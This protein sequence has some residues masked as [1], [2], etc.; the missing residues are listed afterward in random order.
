MVPEDRDN[1]RP[2]PPRAR[3]GAVY[4]L[5][6]IVALLLTVMAL[7]GVSISRVTARSTGDG[8]DWSEAQRLA[9]SGIEHAVVM[10]NA[11]A[12]WRMTFSGT[13]CQKSLGRGTFSW[14]VVDEIDGNLANDA[15]DDY[16]VLA[17]GTV[18]H[19]TYTLHVYMTPKTTGNTYY[20]VST[21]TSLA[22]A[23]GSFIDSYDSTLGP[24]GGSNVSS[25]AA[26]VTN[27]TA[28][29]SVSLANNTQIRGSLRVGVGGDP[30]EVISRPEGVTG[31]KWALYQPATVPTVTAPTGMG[32]STGSLATSNNQTVTISSNTHIDTLSLANGSTLQISGN[33]TIQADG[34]VT[35]NQGAKIQVLPGASLKL[36]FGSTLDVKNNAIGMIVDGQNLS[37]LQVL[38][39]G[40]G[41]VSL[42]NSQVQGVIIAPNSDL[43]M[44]SN[45]QVFGAVATKSLAMSGN[46]TLHQDKRITS[47]TDFVNVGYSPPSNARTVEWRQVIH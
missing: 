7:A 14:R 43:T 32:T 24:Y 17:A 8:R 22:L 6:L 3:R 36:Y 18:G 44:T 28:D 15:T 11:D 9:F 40:A 46:A 34:P 10:I 35:I 1:T 20:G 31:T 5:V 2:L 37:R 21:P 23:S 33:V 47:G 39:F 26:I 27:T 4:A 16:V 29:S 42:T 45:A 30:N 38:G 19:A 13:T 41:A 25:K 12:N